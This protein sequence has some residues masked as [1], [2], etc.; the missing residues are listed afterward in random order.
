MSSFT[1]PDGTRVD[2]LMLPDGDLPAKK[3]TTMPTKT[4][5]EIEEM[6]EKIWR[7]ESF[8]ITGRDRTVGWSDVSP[9]DQEKYRFL[10]RH[11]FGAPRPPEEQYLVWSNEHKG[12]WRADSAG[13]TSSSKEAG[14]YSRGE[15]IEICRWGK[16]GW[17]KHDDV[18]DEL[19]IRLAD[20][21]EDLL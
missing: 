9:A 1:L 17:R 14:R 15:A 21:P 16:S 7:A 19:P 13:Y 20:V 2:E 5:T 11:V 3:D 8:R 12:W 6:A 4:E 10:A 18:P